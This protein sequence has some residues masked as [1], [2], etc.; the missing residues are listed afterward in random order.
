M[1]TTQGFSWVRLCFVVSNCIKFS[2][3]LHAGTYR[4]LA[5]CLRAGTQVNSTDRCQPQFLFVV[6]FQ[7]AWFFKK[8]GEEAFPTSIHF[9]LIRQLTESTAVK[10]APRFYS[11]WQAMIGMRKKEVFEPPEL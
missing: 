5:E 4:P 11:P 2:K 1:G 10:V 6:F 7:E 3:W 8:F 9:N